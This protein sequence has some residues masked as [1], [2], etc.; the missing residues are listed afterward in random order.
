MKNN[1]DSLQFKIR[2]KPVKYLAIFMMHSYL[3]F[4]F[5][6]ENASD[7]FPAISILACS[8]LFYLF[9]ISFPFS[10]SFLCLPVHQRQSF[11]L[12]T[13]L[14]TTLRLHSKCLS[15]NRL[16]LFIFNRWL[17]PG[18]CFSFLFLPPLLV[19]VDNFGENYYWFSGVFCIVPSEKRTVFKLGK[20]P[21]EIPYLLE[22][23]GSSKRWTQCKSKASDDRDDLLIEERRA[24][25]VESVKTNLARSREEF[26]FAGRLILRHVRWLK[27]LAVETKERPTWARHE[28]S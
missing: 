18:D 3:H 12:E 27:Q 28:R 14:P 19:E 4:F 11:A 16:K 8:T 23:L 24:G 7:L 9:L 2:D 26:R 15:F 5:Y 17:V 21:N 25:S 6:L 20:L 1:R 13:H 22:W 10:I